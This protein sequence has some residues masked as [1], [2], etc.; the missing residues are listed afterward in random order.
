MTRHKVATT[1]EFDDEPSR[2]ITEIKGREV[3]VFNLDGGFHAVANYCIHAGGPLCAGK[4]T[5]RMVGGEDGWEW[6]FDDE[7]RYI[8]CPWHFWKF[9]I[10]SGVNV[11]DDRYQVPTYETEIDGDDIYVVL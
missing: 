7:P 8:T 2:V 5:G 11:D 3:A 4:R 6:E 9:D 1:D 10:T